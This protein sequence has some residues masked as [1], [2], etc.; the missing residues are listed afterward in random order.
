MMLPP[1]VP[2]LDVQDQFGRK[3]QILFL[4]EINH[5]L[6]MRRRMLDTY[7]LN[8]ISNFIEN[9]ILNRIMLIIK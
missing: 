1:F 3:W 2:K 9:V 7:E 4:G 5:S 6:L 8:Y